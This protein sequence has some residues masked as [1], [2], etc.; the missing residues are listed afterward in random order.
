MMNV[1]DILKIKS[2]S[3]SKLIAGENGIS[4]E[5]SGV[6]VLEALD[7]ENWGRSGEVILSSYFALQNLSHEELDKFVKKLY[8]IGIS[9]LILKTDRLVHNIPDKL[10]ELCDL[11]IIPL[12]QIGKGIKYELIILEILGP[13]INKNV[14]LLNKYYDIHSELTNLSLK[15]P[16]FKNILYE[17]K[18]MLSC[19]ISLINIEKNTEIT[20]SEDLSEIE[21]LKETPIIKEKYMYYTYIRRTVLYLKSNKV[22]TQVK[23][24]IPYPGFNDYELII[25]ET[26]QNISAED[27]MVIENAV[28]FLQME[29]LNKYVVSQNK[30][31]QKNNILSDLLNDRIYEKKDI[32][33]VLELLQI[34]KFKKYEIT[35]V[36]L[37]FKEESRNHDKEAMVPILRQIR[38]K[39]KLFYRNIAFLD[40]SDRIV[41]INNFD[42]DEKAFK[43]ERIQKIMTSLEENNFLKDFHYKIS[44]SSKVEKMDI[45]KANREILDTQKILNLFHN[46]NKILPYEE[47][48][49]Y[50]LFL[51][52][53]SLGTL[54]NFVSPRI[55]SFR[56]ERPQLFETLTIFLDTN[57]SYILTSEKLFLHP[58]TV[59]Y[60]ID[61]IKSLLNTEF[62]DPEEI[63]QIQV[64]SRLFKLIE[65]EK[66][67]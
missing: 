39:F 27:F 61:K 6:N 10:I 62:K 42:D 50:K 31:Q 64:A 21:I 20:T 37:Y 2:L 51:D 45:P 41:F 24:N 18:D 49:I 60:R 1:R 32:D 54:E 55:N 19:D 26:N 7:I 30:F 4:N 8:D 44:V 22:G 38:N 3:E 23:V 35:L 28:K 25:H 33:E 11:Y 52:S 47:L 58:K 53:N 65:K 34:Y 36:K 5:I 56:C 17:F 46:S 57:Q 63:L 15:M 40:K 48:G 13:I 67:K 14:H 9:S 16:S 66:I 12:I 43:L 29:L 59:R